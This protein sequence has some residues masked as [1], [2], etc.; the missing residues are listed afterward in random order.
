[1]LENRLRKVIRPIVRS[2]LKENN[3][4]PRTESNKPVKHLS[5]K[6]GD[7]LG[8]SEFPNF[9]ATG[10]ISGMKK[11]YYGKGA[12][13]VKCGSFIYHVSSEPD[14]YFKEANDRPYN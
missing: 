1:M 14:I 10:N 13:L 9:S 3:Y 2:I 12:L 8:I 7:R 4:N 11:Q 5:K 6:D